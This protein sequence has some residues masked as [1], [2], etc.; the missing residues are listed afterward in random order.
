MEKTKN[1]LIEK[2]PL[3]R[4]MVLYGIFGLFSAS[5]DTLSFASLSGLLSVYV[6]NFI[7]INIGITISFLLN[8]FLNFRKTTFIKKRVIKFFMV[9][10]MGLLI[11]MAIMWAGLNILPGSKLLVK[12]V[13]VVIVAVIQYILNKF[14]T[15]G[16]D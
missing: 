16:R 3:L 4:E 7:S 5:M 6:S 2:L 14:I 11:S 10:Y 13:S 1:Y 15:Y 9:G 12:I 8:T